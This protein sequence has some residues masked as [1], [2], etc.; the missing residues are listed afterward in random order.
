MLLRACQVHSCL[1]LPEVTL[2]IQQIATGD[3]FWAQARAECSVLG[4]ILFTPRPDGTALKR[5]VLFVSECIEHTSLAAGVQLNLIREMLGKKAQ[6]CHLRVWCD[7]GPHYR[8]ADF[9]SYFSHEWILHLGARVTLSYF[10][11]KHGK[12]QVDALFST[13]NHWCE[14]MAKKEGCSVESVPDLVSKMQE[15]A[16]LEMKK[17]PDGLQY[18]VIHWKT[19][20]KPEKAWVGNSP[21]KFF[22]TRTY[23]LEG[24]AYGPKKD[25]LH[26]RNKRF[27]DLS[28]GETVTFAFSQEPIL[29]RTWRKGFFSNPR[30]KRSFP[31]KNSQS[32]I[33]E[34][35]SLLQVHD[36]EPMKEDAL[37][38]RLGKYQRALQVKRARGARQRRVLSKLAQDSDSSSSSS[39]ETS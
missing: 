13:V 6:G 21:K 7:V 16:R 22:I 31:T 10:I 12:G 33:L 24:S 4:V 1:A 17:D 19:D 34:R 37:S 11:E 9:I 2:P 32:A 29:D 14:R 3:S 36:I 35:H 26:W 18:T 8:A 20:A 25:Q 15:E 27:S 5:G 39:S 38:Q 28:A 23:C 30:W